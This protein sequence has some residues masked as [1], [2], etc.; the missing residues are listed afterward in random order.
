MTDM[1][2]FKKPGTSHQD[3]KA[4]STAKNM[5]FMFVVFY[6]RCPTFPSSPILIQHQDSRCKA[7]RIKVRTVGV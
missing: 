7:S 1:T 6:Q 5:I 2:E 3:E 4:C